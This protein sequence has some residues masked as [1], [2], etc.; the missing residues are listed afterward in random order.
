[1][2]IRMRFF[3]LLS[4]FFFQIFHV[5]G[6]YVVSDCKRIVGMENGIY[7]TLLLVQ[8]SG[9]FINN[10][11]VHYFGV[12]RLTNHGGFSELAAQTCAALLGTSCSTPVGQSGHHVFGS[13]V[14]QTL[15]DGTAALRMRKVTLGR[16]ISLS[17]EWQIADTLLWQS[18]MI[19]TDRTDPSHRVQFLNGASVSGA[20]SSHHID[21]YAGY[22][23]SGTMLLPL[24]DGSKTGML[25]LTGPCLEGV[26]AAYFSSDPGSA[27]LPV[28]GPYPTQEIGEGLFAVSPEEYWAV[29][30]ADSTQV[31]LHFDTLSDL[32]VLTSQLYELRVVGWDG[33]KWA[34]LGHAGAT[35]A[36]EGA[37]TLMSHPF[38][39]TEYSVVT[40]GAGEGCG[41]VFASGGE[42]TSQTTCAGA[43]MT[44]MVWVTTG[45]N[46]IAVDGVTGLPQGVMATWAGGRLVVS[47]EPLETGSFAF[48]IVLDGCP[49]LSV[50][51]T[52]TVENNPAVCPCEDEA[53]TFSGDIPS[54][55]YITSLTI[56]SSGRVAAGGQVLFRAAQSI[57]LLPG[58]TAEPGS[59]FTAAIEACG[60]TEPL[61]L[62][63]EDE[64]DPEG[65]NTAVSR[66]E[67][68][69]A[70]AVGSV[71]E[72]LA[73]RVW[74]NPFTSEMMVEFELPSEAE[75]YLTLQSVHGGRISELM[76]GQ[77]LPEGT[78][79]VTVEGRNLPAG[80]Y[81]LTL[82]AAGRMAT[83]RVVKIQD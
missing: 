33:S 70:E 48:Q 14:G 23:G 11:E 58:F 26:H 40:I 38:N 6:Q 65:E 25:A 4:F 18:G 27:T 31:T 59:A 47:G 82:Q 28:G 77:E 3:I 62:Q 75:V 80:L 42:D 76:S 20:S 49:G 1:M 67:N 57:T 79:R 72:V 68:P 46:G 15:I 2:S 53:M 32:E 45:V 71:S 83:H 41:A 56:V 9:T 12:T 35:G 22:T 24:G 43:E 39:P 8:P 55:A 19:T 16:D 5:S 54:G 74:P 10:G 21:G 13:R 66:S 63:P 60:G 34:D 52:L 50:S 17:N 51:G 61:P 44:P 81:V 78:H 64:S 7:D 69:P 73:S 36:L 37:G 29:S 30:G